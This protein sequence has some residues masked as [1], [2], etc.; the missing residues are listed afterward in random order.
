MIYLNAISVRLFQFEVIEMK[1]FSFGY[2]CY[3]NILYVT[4]I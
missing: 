1:N 4:I 2:H 3:D